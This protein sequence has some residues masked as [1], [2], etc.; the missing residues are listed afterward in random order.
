M[1]LEYN[2]YVPELRM[3]K[4]EFPSRIVTEIIQHP[5]YEEYVYVYYL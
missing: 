5:L 3:N 4:T 1:C 2:V